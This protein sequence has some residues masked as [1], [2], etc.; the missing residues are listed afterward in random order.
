MAFSFAL[1]ASLPEQDV[2]DGIGVRHVLHTS[3]LL[4][5]DRCTWFDDPTGG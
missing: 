4:S 2:I 3:Q 1:R 5:P